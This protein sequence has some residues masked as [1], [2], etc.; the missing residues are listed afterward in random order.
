MDAV[1]KVELITGALVFAIGAAEAIFIH[2]VG[3]INWWVAWFIAAASSSGLQASMKITAN[4][5]L[6]DISD[7]ELVRVSALANALEEKVA[8]LESEIENLKANRD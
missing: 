7:T 4:R 2:W 6:F 1:K 8:D 3:D 5:K